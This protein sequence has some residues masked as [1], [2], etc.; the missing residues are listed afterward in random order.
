MMSPVPRLEEEKG[1]NTLEGGG[2]RCLRWMGQGIER[3]LEL[4]EP[5][6]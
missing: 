3:K 1:E 4:E 6:V 5:K 2:R